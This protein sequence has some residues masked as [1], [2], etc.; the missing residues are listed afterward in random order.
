MH[1]NTRACSKCKLEKTL[2][3]FY[4]T[5]NGIYFR[6]EC[7]KCSNARSRD[8]Y[9]NNRVAAL[10]TKLQYHLSV[11]YKLTAEAWEA[12]FVKQNGACAICKQ[13]ETKFNNKSQQLQKLCVDHNHKTG[14]VRGLLCNNCNQILGRL[15]ENRDTIRRMYWYLEK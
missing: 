1:T 8:Q 11:N 5:S 12:L 2:D 4:K 10:H 13:P 14:K 15:N 3:S 6:G 9:H 7:K